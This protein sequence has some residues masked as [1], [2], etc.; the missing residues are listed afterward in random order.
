MIVCIDGPNFA[1][2]STIIS[3]VKSKIKDLIIIEDSQ[4]YKTAQ[5]C[6]SFYNARIKLQQEYNLKTTT[7]NVLLCRWFPSMYVFD[8]VTNFSEFVKP[9][10]T[11][12][13]LSSL[14][15]LKQRQKLRDDFPVKMDLELQ[16]AKF[17]SAAQF[18][19]CRC[20]ENND[21]NSLNDIS[22]QIID[23]FLGE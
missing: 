12:V 7:K 3:K 20:V 13:V 16:I 10:H 14:N 2:K 8:E 18:L 6:G 11:F 4:I 1:G 22:N 9:N 15:V 19:N 5:C 21:E 17:K 23:C